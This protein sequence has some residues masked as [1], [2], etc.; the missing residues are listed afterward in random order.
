MHVVCCA[1]LS[2]FW[3]QP[4]DGGLGEHVCCT[5]VKRNCC[6]QTNST[7]LTHCRPG[8]C[9]AKGYPVAEW[10]AYPLTTVAKSI[11]LPLCQVW[12]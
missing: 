2:R 1:A 8:M 10:P 12:R 3:H 5:S 11:I 4:A 9:S 6:K 7:L